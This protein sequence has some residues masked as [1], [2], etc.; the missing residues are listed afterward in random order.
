VARYGGEEF[1]LIL[2]ETTKRAAHERPPG[3]RSNV[4]ASPVV[5]GSDHTASPSAWA[6]TFPRTAAPAEPGRTRQ[7]LYQSKRRPQPGQQLQ[8]SHHRV[9]RYRLR[10]LRQ[11]PVEHCA[12]VATSTAGPPGRPHAPQETGPSGPSG[13]DPG[14]TNTSSWSTTSGCLIPFSIERSLGR[15]WANNPC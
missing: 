3:V 12:V 2:P 13:L 10:R 14:T 6:C 15:Y 1:A 8:P 9:F 11:A 7:A 5:L 4:E